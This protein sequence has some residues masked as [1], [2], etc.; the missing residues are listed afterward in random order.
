MV[1]RQGKIDERF[2]IT[3]EKLRSIR[4]S[5]EK[6]LLTQAWSLRETDLYSYQRQLDRI[7]E[8][9]INGNFEDEQGNKADLHAQRVQDFPEY[10]HETAIADNVRLYSICFAAAMHT[11]IV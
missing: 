7:D 1:P 5:L 2:K 4:N 6:L 9:R 10:F 11:F 3:Y 8:A